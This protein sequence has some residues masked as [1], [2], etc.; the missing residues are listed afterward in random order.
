MSAARIWRTWLGAGGIPGPLDRLLAHERVDGPTFRALTVAATWA[1]TVAAAL[2]PRDTAVLDQLRTIDPKDVLAGSALCAGGAAPDPVRRAM[3]TLRRRL[4][5]DPSWAAACLRHGVP[6]GFAPHVERRAARSGDD[7]VRSWLAAQTSRPPLW[8]RPR[9]PNVADALRTDGYRV[10]AHDG[11]LTVE[12]ARGIESSGVYREGRIEVQDAASQRCGAM[13]ALRPGQI[14]W[15]VC[16]GRGGKT[17]QMADTLGGRGAVHAT[18]IDEHKL[19]ALKI[20]LRRA[21]LAGVVR[22]HRWDGVEVPV[23][24]PEARKGFDVV[25]VDAPCSSTGTWRRNPDARLRVDPDEIGRFPELQRRLLA[26]GAKALGP[27]GTLIYATCSFAVHEDEDVVDAV[28]AEAGLTVKQSAWF[29]PPSLDS[30]SLFASVL[31]R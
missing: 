9:D 11:A 25:L 20:R 8:V 14:A 17:V 27:R 28:A 6:A 13:A 30:D 10:E 16:A 4:D 18:D 5:A 1:A 19:K 21:G 31:Q 23:F 15:D 7:V 29:G 12:G 24:G 2:G 22:I 26:L 3:S